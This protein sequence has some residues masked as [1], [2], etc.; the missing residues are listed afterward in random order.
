MLAAQEGTR[1]LA[2]PP[3]HPRW[4][5]RFSGASAEGRWARHFL[6]YRYLFPELRPTAD[7]QSI[8][9]LER[10]TVVVELGSACIMCGYFSVPDGACG[11]G[12]RSLLL[13]TLPLVALGSPLL[14]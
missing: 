9:L 8:I 12:A 4:G 1:L 13:L 5:D 3:F 7:G 6:A 2:V 10:G 14:P 11:A